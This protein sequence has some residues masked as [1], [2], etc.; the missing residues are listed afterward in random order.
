VPADSVILAG[1]VEAD[2]ALYEALAERIEEVYAVG[3]CTGL[4]LI[5]KATLEGARAACA[6]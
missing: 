4:G 5:R 2:P 1:E 3:D 6:L